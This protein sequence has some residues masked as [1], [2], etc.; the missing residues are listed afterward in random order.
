MRHAAQ[1]LFSSEISWIFNDREWL[2]VLEN[3]LSQRG[4]AVSALLACWRS[5]ISPYNS[6]R[7]VTEVLLAMLSRVETVPVASWLQEALTSLPDIAAPVRSRDD[8]HDKTATH[9]SSL[10][11]HGY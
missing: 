2:K 9:D 11:L 3:V 4:S 6:L 7:D 1:S 10:N 5:W 8:T